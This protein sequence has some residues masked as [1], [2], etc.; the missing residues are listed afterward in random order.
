MVNSFA[1]MGMTDP[2]AGKDNF[3]DVFQSI[4]ELSMDNSFYAK[5][6]MEP[7][8]EFQKTGKKPA[9]KGLSDNMGP[10][11]VF[12]PSRKLCITIV[13]ALLHFAKTDL[14]SDI[15]LKFGLFEE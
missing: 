1:E 2:F 7:L 5:N 6:I 14:K 15:L 8:E 9:D 12:L 10:K 3:Y 11:C 13:R 4:D